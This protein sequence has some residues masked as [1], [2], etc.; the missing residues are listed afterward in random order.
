MTPTKATG[1]SRS[2]S[3]RA[4]TAC[5]S[6]PRRR[7]SCRRSSRRCAPRHPTS[8]CRCGTAGSSGPTGGTVF[9]R[10][11]A[12]DGRV[13]WT[14]P[15]ARIADMIRAVTHPYPGAFVGDGASRLF[16]WGG[17]AVPRVE[18]GAP[19][20]TLLEILPG[21][22]IEVATGEG[23]LRLTHVQSAGAAEQPADAWALGRGLRPGVRL[24][25][26]RVK[27]GVPS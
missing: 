19:P 7:P 9:P 21:R 6:S 2:P 12:E 25:K 18:H 20:G 17:G 22:G 5:P 3:S 11:R 16:L 8:C 13:E 24:T 1:S 15:A 27:I 23:T 10:R 26:E 14:W 4:F